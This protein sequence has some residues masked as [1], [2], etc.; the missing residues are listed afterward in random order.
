[1]S[2]KILGAND[3]PQLAHLYLST[4][5]AIITLKVEGICIDKM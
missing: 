4:P 1:M 3:F 2:G 5:I